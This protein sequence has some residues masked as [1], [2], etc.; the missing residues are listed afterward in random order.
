MIFNAEKKK[1]FLIHVNTFAIGQ[2][3][4]HIG[5]EKAHNFQNP[6]FN[7]QATKIQIKAKLAGYGSGLTNGLIS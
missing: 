5:I 2:R 7:F 6:P 3:F 4:S 1:A